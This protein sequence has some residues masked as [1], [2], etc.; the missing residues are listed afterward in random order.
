MKVIGADNYEHMSRLAA[1]IIFQRVH[2]HPSS[3][4]GLATGSTPEGTYQQLI[5]NHREYGTSYKQVT[6]I[7]LDEYIGLPSG[8]PNSFRQFMNE[9]LFSKLDLRSEQTHLPDGTASDLD[10]ECKRYDILI[11][12]K[13][14]IDLQLLG[15][16]KNGHIGFNEPGTSFRSRTHIVTLTESTRK[17]NAR[18]FES[19]SEVPE[20][21]ITMGIQTILQS[22]KILLLASGASK[23]EAIGRLLE[24][25]VSEDFPASALNLHDDVTLIADREALS[26]V[27]E[28]KGAKH[29]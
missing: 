24:G 17:A 14:G 4:L 11:E 1:A 22:K 23:A 2:T 18:F 7:N 21:A 8:H 26:L 25:K 3:V 12:H 5:Q 10:K 27:E 6:T 29:G 28:E 20:R 16:G 9:R 13:G 19:L 15:I